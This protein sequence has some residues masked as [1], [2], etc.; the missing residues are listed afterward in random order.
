M[1]RANV[2]DKTVKTSYFPCPGCGK[3]LRHD[4]ELQGKPVRCP[5]CG[6]GFRMPYPMPTATAPPK[7]AAPN[8]EALPRIIEQNGRKLT[9]RRKRRRRSL[10][11]STLKIC[12]TGAVAIVLW[13]VF[14]GDGSRDRK[15]KEAVMGLLTRESR[16]EQC[17]TIIR[18]YLRQELNKGSLAG[19]LD[20]VEIEWSEPEKVRWGR[21]LVGVDLEPDDMV[22]AVMFRF[23]LERKPETEVRETPSGASGAYYRARDEL[24]LSSMTER[25]FTQAFAIKNGQVVHVENRS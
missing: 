10:L 25:T 21:H 22:T 13:T 7:P 6:Q 17:Q 4:T 11:F 2:D 24:R 3:R 16:L 19:R 9:G 1:I 20:I 8:Q 23:Q 18:R 12:L 14:V 5:K 15:V